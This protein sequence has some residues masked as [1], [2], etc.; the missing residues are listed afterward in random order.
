MRHSIALVLCLL[1]FAGTAQA[2]SAP[3]VKAKILSFDGKV[4][5]LDTDAAA[6]APPARTAPAPRR[7]GGASRNG[8]A[9][10][11]TAGAPQQQGAS[12]PAGG[13]LSVGLMPATLLVAEKPSVRQALRVGDFVGAVGKLAG[14]TLD[15]RNIYIYP[16]ALRGANEGR[17]ADGNELRVGGT[18]TA[19]TG[20]GLTLRYRGLGE[21]G[22]VCAGRALPAAVSPKSCAGEISVRLDTETPVSLL[23]PGDKS[24]LSPGAV[25][26]VSLART[27]DGGMVTPGVIVEKTQSS[28]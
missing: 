12:A 14:G 13:K 24:L 11:T 5:V 20:D 10:A 27:T 28:P 15:A 8:G 25:A 26:T 6:F 23:V 22:G 7:T 2:A 4:L 18:I 19:L 21:D 1:A 17:F 16:D 3:R 9:A